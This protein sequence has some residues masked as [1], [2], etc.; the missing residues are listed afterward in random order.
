MKGVL[1][2]DNKYNYG[3]NEEKREEPARIEPP[4][5]EDGIIEEA[6]QTEQRTEQE[7]T[8][9]YEKPPVYES[10]TQESRT[11]ESQTRESQ[12]Y[13]SQAYGA[14][15]YEQPDEQSKKQTRRHMRKKKERKPIH[16][17]VKWAICICMALVFGLL[18]S[19]AFQASNVVINKVV[20]NKTTVASSGQ[21]VNSTKVSTNTS[22]DV[23][24]ELADMVENVMPSVVSITNLSVQQVQDFFGGVR[25]YES[26]SSGSGIIIGQ[27]DSEL[28]IVTNNHVVE[29]S[30]TLTVTFVDEESVEAQVKGR[31]S[32]IDLAV[33]A[34]QLDQIKD[35]TMKE[36][37]TATL[38][39]S[40][41]IRVGE[42][43]IAIGNALGY[44]QSVTN[45]IISA[46]DRTVDGFET[47][48]I[49]TNAAINPG[50]SG[51]A[52]LNAKGEVIGINT[53]KVNA[54]AVEGMG[55]AIPISD[56]T[57]VI[58]DLMNRQTRTK[59]DESQRGALGIS[60]TDVDS[61]SAQVY[62]MPEG[63]FISEVTKDGGAEKAGL[64]KGSIITEFDGTKIDGMD[65]LKAQLEYYKAGETVDVTV[66]V[67]EKNGE[68]KEQTVQ[69]TLGEASK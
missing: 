16:I 57:D 68:Y 9:Y 67:P 33:V 28:L 56:V 35:S 50:N 59:V 38:G 19:A 53:V 24:S 60:G 7:N 10:S 69:V 42:P 29:G 27:N 46:K 13:E 11:Q 65:T 20:G 30:S 1:T 31:N 39:D 34:V 36:I 12:S 52:L 4:V 61:Q 55:Y 18:A 21:K 23:D 41:A 64:T 3:N 37:K 66:Q 45:G 15:T 63:V 8:S 5:P 32:N 25:E 51:G 49:Q 6:A 62:N 26:Q 44:G 2:M 58:N 48:L 54:D 17:G 43:A 47:T 40:D 14:P 22:S